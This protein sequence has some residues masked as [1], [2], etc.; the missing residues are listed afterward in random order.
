MNI[1]LVKKYILKLE[2]CFEKIE[3]CEDTPIYDIKGNEI[4]NK[5]QYFKNNYLKLLK[6]YDFLKKE[7]LYKEFKTKSL[8]VQKDK[9]ILIGAEILKDSINIVMWD[10]INNDILTEYTIEEFYTDIFQNVYEI[11][12]MDLK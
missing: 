7:W 11:K 5:I 8:L 12:D 3:E 9:W 1:N 2:E 6:N 4:E 10:Y